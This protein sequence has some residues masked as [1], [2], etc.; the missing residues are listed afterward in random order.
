MDPWQSGA[1]PTSGAKERPAVVLWFRIFCVAT[2]LLYLSIAAAGVAFFFVPE[3]QSDREIDA[4]VMGVLLSG[5]GLGLAALFIAPFFFAPSKGSW[6]F[7]LVLIGLTMSSCCFWPVSIPLLI[8]WIRA[9]NKEY[10]G[11]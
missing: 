10:F 1:D 5:L 2:A 4:T 3:L 11:A 7:G 8:Y 9:D 6:I